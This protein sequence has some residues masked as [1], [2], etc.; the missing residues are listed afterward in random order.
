MRRNG[1]Q[2]KVS[3]EELNDEELLLTP[4]TVHGFSLSDKLWCKS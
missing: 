2:E 3:R 1:E 4:T